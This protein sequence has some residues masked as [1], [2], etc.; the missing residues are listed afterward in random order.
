[1]VYESTSSH[2]S[3]LAQDEIMTLLW[4]ST[5]LTIAVYCGQLLGV[6]AAR[7][8]SP[9]LSAQ[10]LS[11]TSSSLL[12]CSRSMEGIGSTGPRVREQR[13]S[14]C[15]DYGRRGPSHINSP[16]HQYQSREIHTSMKS[17][18]RDSSCFGRRPFLVTRTRKPFPI[19]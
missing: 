2:G 1:M 17:S 10:S 5:V 18:T 11:P 6:S 8:S 12:A 19:L 4:D 14:A 3:R 7:T 9:E 13:Q 16:A 15:Y